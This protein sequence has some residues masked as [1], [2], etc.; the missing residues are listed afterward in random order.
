[1]E[2]NT[3]INRIF[4]EEMAKI[5]SNTISDKEL[6]EMYKNKLNKANYRT[7]NKKNEKRR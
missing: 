7:K 3:E 5:F 6:I 2:L 1:M 4:G